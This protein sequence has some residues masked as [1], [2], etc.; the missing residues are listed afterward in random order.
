VGGKGTGKTSLLRL[1]LETADTSPGATADQKAAVDQFLKGSTKA[2]QAIQ[3]ACVEICESRFDRV[4]FSVIDTPGL[5]FTEGRELKLE[6]QVNTVLK[7][8]DAQYADTMSE[9]RTV[10]NST[11]VLA[12]PPAPLKPP[13]FRNPKLFD[14]PKETNISTCKWHHPPKLALNINEN[15]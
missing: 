15:S 11:S 9:V 1:L 6:R 8:V 3:T 4:L 7:Y 14:S 13:F 12:S 2:T 10:L 5:D